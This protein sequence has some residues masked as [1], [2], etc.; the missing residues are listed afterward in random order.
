MAGAAP[1]MSSDHAGVDERSAEAF[2]VGFDAGAAG[3]AAPASAGHPVGRR[4]RPSAIARR[5]NSTAP[6]MSKGFARYSNAPPRN[7]VTALSRSE[8]A[9]MM[10]TGISGCASATLV[11]R[12][13]PEIPGMRTSETRT[14]GASAPS[15]NALKT[16]SPRSNARNVI[17]ARVSA[18]SSTQRMERSSSAIQTGPSA[19]SVRSSVMSVLS[20]MAGSV[21]GG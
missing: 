12:S 14:S 17:P 10:M 16:A 5:I 8:K 4:R 2:V 6:S 21:R 7:A 19:P 18:F 1:T 3:A 15:S 13:V 11:S 20:F 9:V